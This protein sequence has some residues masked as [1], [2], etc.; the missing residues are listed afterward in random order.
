MFTLDRIVC[1]PGVVSGKP[2]IKGTRLTV[3]VLLDQ[4][5]NGHSID[6][7]LLDFP[8][9]QRE[10]VIAALQ[11]ASLRVQEEEVVLSV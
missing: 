1:T 5:A 8:Y 7:V 9:I 6:E 11:Y 2:R 4:L 10:D 3:G